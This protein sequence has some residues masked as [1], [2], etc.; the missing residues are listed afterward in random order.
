MSPATYNA[1]GEVI[2]QAS[3][4]V[5]DASKEHTVISGD[6]TL[7][8]SDANITGEIHATSGE[9][10]GTITATG[11]KI[12]NLTIQS[13]ENMSDTVNAIEGDK[14]IFRVEVDSSNG[15]LTYYNKQFTTML[16][17]N[18]YIGNIP[19]TSAEYNNYNFQWEKSVD[20]NTWEVISGQTSRSW[21]YQNTFTEQQY[22]RCIMT[23]KS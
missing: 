2:T 22:I 4:S 19:L 8:A 5:G 14:S 11:G 18:A 15:N 20:G 13:I 6:G 23:K 12:G 7:T 16:T 3:I 9:F 21:S 1:S 10:K 17:A